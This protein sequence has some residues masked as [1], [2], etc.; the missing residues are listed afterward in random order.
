MFTRVA[1][2]ILAA[3]LMAAPASAQDGAD[4]EAKITQIFAHTLPNLPGKSVKGVLVEY[5]PG[6]HSAAH[7]HAPSAFIAATVLDGA[8]RS[9][10]GDA[11]EAVYRKGDTFFETP[12]AHHAVS[13]NASATAPARLLA[14][15]V[16]NTDET[17]L[18]IPDRE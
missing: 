7:T 14:V 11:P 12:G 5:G 16:V 3:A 9:K 17:V 4:R 18:T 15:F 13:A 6:G 2:M 10:V 8:I 1:G